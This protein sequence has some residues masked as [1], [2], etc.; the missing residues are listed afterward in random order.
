MATVHF[1][2]THQDLVASILVLMYVEDNFDGF[3][4][5][6]V[7]TDSVADGMLYEY[8][9]NIAYVKQALYTKLHREGDLLLDS[10]PVFRP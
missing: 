3:V 7:S 8:I 1:D 6:K 2:V 4:V 10:R 9:Q 5:V